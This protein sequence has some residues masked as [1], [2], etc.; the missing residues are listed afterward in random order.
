MTTNSWSS[1]SLC[2]HAKFHEYSYIFIAK[3]EFLLGDYVQIHVMCVKFLYLLL[4]LSPL[5][6]PSIPRNQ[7]K[8]GF[9]K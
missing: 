2:N 4:G 1:V 8:Q 7:S 3:T 5:P 6:S 9:G